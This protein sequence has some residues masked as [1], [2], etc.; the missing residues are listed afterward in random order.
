MFRLKDDIEVIYAA[1]CSGREGTWGDDGYG[2]AKPCPY[3][4]MVWL[5][6]DGE[7]DPDIE[8][9]GAVIIYFRLRFGLVN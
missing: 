5:H 4:N 9:I 7:D 6:C 1:K 8:N 3:L 2:L